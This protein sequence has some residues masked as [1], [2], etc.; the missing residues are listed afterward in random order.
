MHF[1]QILHMKNVLYSYSQEFGYPGAGD[2]GDI[3]YI[4][5]HPTREALWICIS[6]YLLYGTMFDTQTANLGIFKMA[7]KLQFKTILN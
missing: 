5:Y 7:P 6:T 2:L 4:V 3:Y 1:F